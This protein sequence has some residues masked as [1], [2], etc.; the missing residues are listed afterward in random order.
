MANKLPELIEF[1]ENLQPSDID[2]LGELYA[3]DAIFKDPFNEVRGI[4]AIRHIFRHMFVQVDQPRFVV[5]AKFTGDDGA[6][7][8]W[9]FSFRTR[10]FAG[11]GAQPMCIR[12]ASHLRFNAADQ[13]IEHR[14][15]WDAAEE[16]Y[17]KLPLLGA[18]MRRLQAAGRA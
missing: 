17:A 6:M 3:A 4:D 2:N 12:G 10:G 5:T 16:L 18:V 11:A 13:V 8:L 9:D 15:Y 7:L 14:D 1:Y